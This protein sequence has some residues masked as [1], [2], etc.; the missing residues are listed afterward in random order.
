MLI[1]H[2]VCEGLSQVVERRLPDLMEWEKKKTNEVYEHTKLCEGLK[3]DVSRFRKCVEKFTEN[4]WKYQIGS[5][6]FTYGEGKDYWAEITPKN[7]QNYDKR[8]YHVA[9]QVHREGKI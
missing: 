3:P 1:H 8:K 5:A 7:F 6:P 9:R 4:A 2:Q